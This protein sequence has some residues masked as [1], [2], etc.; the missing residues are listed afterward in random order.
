MDVTDKGKEE[1]DPAEMA[2]GDEAPPGP[3]TAENVCPVCEG[4]GRV[5]GDS[6]ENCAGRGFV[7]EGVG[8]G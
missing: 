1:P 3:S 7:V 8:G 6:C 2:P 4:S 5:D